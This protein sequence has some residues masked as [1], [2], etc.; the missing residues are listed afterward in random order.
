MEIPS[1]LPL[2]PWLL[3][4]QSEAMVCPLLF[5]TSELSRWLLKQTDKDSEP[6]MTPQ[7]FCLFQDCLGHLFSQHLIPLDVR[8]AQESKVAVLFRC[9]QTALGISSVLSSI[10]ILPQNLR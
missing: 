6:V 5:L 1:L 10:I 3:I 8:G 9:L 4:A 2:L 7:W